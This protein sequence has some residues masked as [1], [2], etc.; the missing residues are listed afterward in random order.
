M[1]YALFSRVALLEDIPDF[2]LKAGDLVTIVDYLPANEFHG[3]G[4]VVE[5][6]DVLGETL[7]VLTVDE[8]QL[9]SLQPHA[10]PAMREP[11]R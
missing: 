6:F 3:N 10:I 1:K 11:V 5:V 4:Y 9:Q 2:Q 7:G 8:N